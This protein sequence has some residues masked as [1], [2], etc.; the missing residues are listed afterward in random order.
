MTKWQ[1]LPRGLW[2]LKWKALGAS[3]RLYW[4]WDFRRFRKTSEFFGRPRTSSGIFGNDCVV[5]KNRST[6]RIKISRL[7]LR[8][9]WQVYSPVKIF[10]S[11]RQ[12]CCSNRQQSPSGSFGRNLVCTCN[13]HD[14]WPSIWLT[15][16][17]HLHTMFKAFQQNQSCAARVY[18]MYF[19]VTIWT[20]GFEETL[21]PEKQQRLAVNNV[22]ET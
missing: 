11:G 4:D 5:F 7:Y 10:L 17:H 22:V 1:Y 20:R 3:S 21:L 9:S 13:N 15:F 2:F 18:V 16:P 19:L 6:P 8:K 14:R 12:A